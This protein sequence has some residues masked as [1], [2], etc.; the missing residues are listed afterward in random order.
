MVLKV[1]QVPGVPSLESVSG[2]FSGILAELV[3][4][5]DSVEQLLDLESS[6]VVELLVGEKIA[7]QLGLGS[8]HELGVVA[9]LAR[10]GLDVGLVDSSEGDSEPVSS[11]GLLGGGVGSGSSPGE[12]GILA[13]GAELFLQLSGGFF[14][15]FLVAS[16]DGSDILA[17]LAVESESSQLVDNKDLGLGGSEAFLGLSDGLLGLLVG[18]D[19]GFVEDI[20]L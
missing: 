3:G 6:A 1:E 2:S 11:F 18:F 5:V 15:G 12:F 16:V 9:L 20:V 8:A 7:G 14:N 4:S 19:G 17:E 13:D 10:D